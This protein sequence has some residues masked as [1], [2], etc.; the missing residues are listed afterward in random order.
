MH[1][2]QTLQMELGVQEA[3]EISRIIVKQTKIHQETT[4]KKIILRPTLSTKALSPVVFQIPCYSSC[5]LLAV[6]EEK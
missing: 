5:L 6:S 2:N 4:P 3:R 1:C